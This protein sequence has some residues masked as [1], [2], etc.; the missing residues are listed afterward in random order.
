MNN[1]ET[2]DTYLEISEKSKAILKEHFAIYLSLVI[3]FSSAVGYFYEYLLLNKFGINIIAF[4]EI[5]DFL[6]SSLKAPILFI[7][8]SV[9]PII[10]LIAVIEI[11]KA[12]KFYEQS[13]S[14]FQEAEALFKSAK[15]SEKRGE[16]AYKSY[17]YQEKE[18]KDYIESLSNNLRNLNL[19]SKI[20]EIFFLLKLKIHYRK[21]YNLGKENLRL[22]NIQKEKIIESENIFN[23]AK[24]QRNLYFRGLVFSILQIIAGFVVPVAIVIFWNFK[25]D[26]D[27]IVENPSKMATVQLR[28]KVILPNPLHSDKPLVLI[29]A[30]NKFLFFY[31]H[32]T[33]K[34][35]STY[36]IPISSII[37]IQYSDFII[38]KPINPAS[39]N[40]IQPN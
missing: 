5:Q 32:G 28:N 26:I 3:F 1:K 18:Y 4:A 15:L 40:N 39:F 37:N 13:A 33:N 31:Q 35:T 17:K 8:I 20:Q 34:K 12:Y 36:A 22:M 6:L 24:K 29:T 11:I 16:E 14:F 19:Y 2:I 38:G 7:Y 30:T 27:R 9:L 23:S 10:T 25:E 21:N